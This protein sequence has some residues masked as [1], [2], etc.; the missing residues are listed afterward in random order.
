MANSEV[1]ICNMALLRLGQSRISSLTQSGLEAELSNVY[2]GATLEE[3]LTDYEWP[4]AIERR[5]LAASSS[6]NLTDFYYKYAIPSQCLRILTFLDGDDFSEVTDEWFIEGAF[7]YSN[8][9]PGYIKYIS[10]ITNPALFTQPFVEALAL[11]I[12]I[13]MCIKMT[14]DQSLMNMLYQEYAVAMQ[15]AMGLSGA[16]SHAEPA[17]TTPWSE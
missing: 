1:S 12:A 6:T 17:A 14:Q 16:N 13:K 15:S 7:V 3:L 10:N 4:F 9:G 11:R 8:R 2:Y 5:S